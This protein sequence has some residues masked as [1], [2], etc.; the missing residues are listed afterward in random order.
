MA[1]APCRKLKQVKAASDKSQFSFRAASEDKA[2]KSKQS[3]SKPSLLERDGDCL[4]REV[5]SVD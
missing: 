3:I 4:A 2:S 1:R 5:I